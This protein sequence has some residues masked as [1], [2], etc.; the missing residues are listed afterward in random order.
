MILKQIRRVFKS[1]GAIKFMSSHDMEQLEGYTF[2]MLGVVALLFGVGILFYV[3]DFARMASL[4]SI[5]LPYTESFI[6]Y[7]S[8]IGTFAIL[9]GIIS[10]ITAFAHML[11]EKKMKI[12]K[13]KR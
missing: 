5:R 11:P 8:I 13:S 6:M 12:T 10:F 3:W 9:L 1:R 4:A 2:L 7:G